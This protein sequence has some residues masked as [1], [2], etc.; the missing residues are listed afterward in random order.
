MD[1]SKTTVKSRGKDAKGEKQRNMFSYLDVVEIVMEFTS[2]GYNEMTQRNQEKLRRLIK[3]GC[4]QVED[5]TVTDSNENRIIKALDFDALK[6]EA[7]KRDLEVDKRN[8]KVECCELGKWR[9]RVQI[10][11]NE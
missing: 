11:N 7:L 3:E 4:I 5:L 9:S 6:E 8:T 2:K 10:F 1:L